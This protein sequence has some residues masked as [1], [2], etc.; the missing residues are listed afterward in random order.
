[1]RFLRFCTRAC[2]AVVAG[3]FLG[4]AFPDF[5]LWPLAVV[6]LTLML[7]VVDSVR[8]WQ[9]GIFGFVFGLVFWLPHL[10]WAII[11]AGGGYMPWLALS[12]IQAF[13]WALWAG[14]A[15]LIARLPWSQRPSGYVIL[16][17][18]SWVGVEQ[19]RSRVPF[20][21]FPW[22]NVAYPQVDAPLGHLAFIGGEALVSFVLLVVAALLRVAFCFGAR[23]DTS[24]T[25]WWSRPLSV[26]LAV[27]LYVL[28]VLVPFSADQQAGAVSIGAVQGGVEVPGRQTYA[29]EGKVTSNHSAQT[30]AM[31]ATRPEL[32]LILWGEGALDHD[33]RVSSVVSS[34]V[35][36]SVRAAG[37][38]VL[39]GFNEYDAERQVT[40]NLYA[41]WYPDTGL[42]EPFYGKQIPVPFGEYI[43]LRNFVSALATEAAQVRVDMEGVKNSSR[44]D[45]R[46]TDGRIVPVGV[47][48]CFEVAYESL[49][50]E[51]VREGAQILVSPSNNYHFRDSV[52]PAQQAQ[53]ARFRAMEF[54]RSM[55]EVSTTGESMLI[56][57]DGGVLAQTPRHTGAF[58]M[59][60]LPLRTSV[61]PASYIALPLAYA[62]MALWGVAVL[63]AWW[64]LLRK[65]GVRGTSKR[66]HSRESRVAKRNS[67]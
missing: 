18:L 33:P 5:S 47:G 43:P 15:S 54:G 36:D 65:R 41:P 20:S 56:R 46:L 50:A 25:R 9:A 55:V 12:F 34:Y 48:I 6:S 11:S 63:G 66:S 23:F 39:V 1:M 64:Y 31:L 16:M 57:P 30:T 62:A 4:A 26:G 10:S 49:W 3:I 61:T 8:V 37:V 24:M 22:G 52:E 45:V 51:G 7:G 13:A 32:D 67:S 14:S 38:P 59:G 60:V 2:T 29:V 44:L 28:P 27:C 40:H 42:T 58:I 19:I 21:G 17:A 35:E 53:M